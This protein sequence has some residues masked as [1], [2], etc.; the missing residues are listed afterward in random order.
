MRRLLTIII[1][2]LAVSA[3]AQV[4]ELPPL[5]IG[6]T[7][8]DTTVT[9]DSA[10]GV[11]RYQYMVTAPATNKAS[12]SAFRI[13]ITGRIVR[14]QLDP[15]LQNNIARDEGRRAPWQP[16][17][18]I[19]V[20]ITVP[21]PATNKGGVSALGWAY[22]RN[23]AGAEIARGTAS[24]GYV[25]ESKQPPGIRNAVIEPSLAP[26]LSITLSGYPPNTEFSP[27][28][29]DVYTVKTTAIGPLD[30]DASTLYSGGGQSPAEVNPFLRYAL[31]TDNRIHLPV[32]T[33]TYGV[34]VVYGSTTIPRTFKATLNG[35]DVTALFKPMV[36]VGQSV[37]IPLVGGTT[38]LQLSV[39]GI[40]SSGRQARDSDTLTFLV[41]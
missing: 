15:D 4:V 25:L 11:Y 7:A 30:Y 27:D 34:L 28:N 38:K 29:A 14:P 39:E 16:A 40:T 20:G 37:K 3:G 22:F 5:S 33:A 23:K 41:P 36:G 9:F 12:V 19:P 21:S 24:T 17:T 18:T 26:W 13:D 32:G 31:P 2:L 35:T 10:R 6:G 1:C 8:L